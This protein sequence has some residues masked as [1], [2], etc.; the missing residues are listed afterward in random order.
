MVIAVP[1]PVIPLTYTL[2]LQWLPCQVPGGVGTVL[3]LV[4]PV[5][6]QCVTA[7]E[8]KLICSFFFSV[9]ACNMK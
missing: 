7:G 6:V 4:G 5:S 1:R 8:N 3:G 2:V 9:A